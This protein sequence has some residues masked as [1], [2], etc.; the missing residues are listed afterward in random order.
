MDSS[1]AN[2]GGDGDRIE[3]N[4]DDSTVGDSGGDNG[5]DRMDRIVEA[6]TVFEKYRF[7]CQMTIVRPENF[8][9]EKSTTFLGC[10]TE[11]LRSSL[12]KWSER[13][14]SVTKV[15]ENRRYFLLMR[16]ARDAS[17]VVMTSLHVFEV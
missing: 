2:S 4:T 16:A 12:A 10:S 9:F 1:V 3:N 17:R 6:C 7:M 13:T 8:H 11:R 14:S 5:S 15:P